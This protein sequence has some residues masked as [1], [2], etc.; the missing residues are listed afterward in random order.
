M[1]SER[2]VTFQTFVHSDEETRTDQVKNMMTETKTMTTTK[3]KTILE[4]CEF[5]TLVTILTIESLN[6]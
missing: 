3:T 5:E 4:T 2:L 6:S 1:P